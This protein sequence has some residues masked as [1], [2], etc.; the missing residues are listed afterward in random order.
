[1]YYNLN[2]K[3]IK[4]KEYNHYKFFMRQKSLEIF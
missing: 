1:M 3:I 2:M 4:V